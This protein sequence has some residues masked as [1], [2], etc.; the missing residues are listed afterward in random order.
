MRSHMD[1]IDQIT[2]IQEAMRELQGLL[3]VLKDTL[4]GD[5]PPAFNKDSM[6]VKKHLRS[7]SNLAKEVEQCHSLKQK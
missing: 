1:A 7:I 4:T 2:K 6:G 3:E 5:S